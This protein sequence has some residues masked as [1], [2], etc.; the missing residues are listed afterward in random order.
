MNINS[1]YR[2]YKA[3]LLIEIFGMNLPLLEDTFMF[4][5][6]LVGWFGGRGPIN[7]NT[8]IMSF[9]IA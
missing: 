3:V 6:G 7:K 9:L 1:F 8:K 2:V 4:L 5:E